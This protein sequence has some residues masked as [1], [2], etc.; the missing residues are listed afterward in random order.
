MA[1]QMCK[2]CNGIYDVDKRGYCIKCN[3]KNQEEFDII[4]EYLRKNPDSIV[5][6]IIDKTGVPF[7]SLNRFV[8]EGGASYK[9][10]NIRPEDIETGEYLK[11]IQR[12]IAGRGKFHSDV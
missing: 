1:R 4:R 9:E 12:L 7:K 11:I 6:E 3:E 8:D 5:L 10:S 2:R